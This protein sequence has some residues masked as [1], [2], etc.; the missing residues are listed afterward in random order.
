M[1]KVKRIIEERK[2][3]SFIEA[4]VSFMVLVITLGFVMSTVLLSVNFV[5]QTNDLQNKAADAK[6]SL[7]MNPASVD[8][9]PK[10]TITAH[11]STI[12]SDEGSIL[13]LTR[14]QDEGFTLYRLYPKES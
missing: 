13:E 9:E 11:D 7:Y 10:I 3:S 1:F 2:G 6:K 5:R 8:G 14:N 12:I 4:I